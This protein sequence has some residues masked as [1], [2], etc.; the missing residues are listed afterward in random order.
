[1]MILL[2]MRSG[3]EVTTVIDSEKQYKFRFRPSY[4]MVTIRKYNSKACGEA[5]RS[6]REQ[7]GVRLIE[8][9]AIAGWSGSQQAKIES[10]RREWDDDLLKVLTQALK[11]SQ[12]SSHVRKRNV[13]RNRRMKRSRIKIPE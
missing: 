7:A 8:I 2:T 12:H 1:M 5:F 4:K 11:L 13:R 10:G 9:A 6:A 3:V